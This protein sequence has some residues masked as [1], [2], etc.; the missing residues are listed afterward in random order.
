M[1]CVTTNVEFIV[2]LNHRSVGAST[3]A[4]DFDDSEF[5]I[6]GRLSQSD[7]EV[8]GDSLDDRIGTATTEHTGG[9][10]TDLNKVLSDGFTFLTIISLSVVWQ[11]G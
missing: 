5:L 8:R 10:G 4:L 2:D 3:E 11:V 6:F 9:R 7:S 1:L